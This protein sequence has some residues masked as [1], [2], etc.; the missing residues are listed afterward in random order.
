MFTVTNNCIV[1]QVFFNSSQSN[2]VHNSTRHWSETDRSI[3]TSSFFLSLLENW[4]N[5]YQL[6]VDWDLSR[7]SRLLK[8]NW[9][10]P[11]DDINQLFEYPGLNPTRLHILTCTHLKMEMTCRF[12]SVWE[13]IVPQSWSSNSELRRSQGSSS[14]LKIE[15]KKA[16]HISAL[17]TFL[18]ICEVT[19]F[20]K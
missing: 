20:I 7:F 19:L 2:L 15:V 16:L 4:D 9:A 8:N 13:F 10:R 17:S 11:C 3:I 5:V 18:H 6:P 14:V 1:F 12:E